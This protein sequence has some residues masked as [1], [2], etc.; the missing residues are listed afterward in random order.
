[1]TKRKKLV[2]VFS[3]PSTMTM[4][5]KKA[6]LND[7]EEVF[8][9]QVPSINYPLSFLKDPRLANEKKKPQQSTAPPLIYLRRILIGVLHIMHPHSVSMIQTKTAEPS[10]QYNYLEI[11]HALATAIGIFTSNF[12]LPP[13]PFPS[14]TFLSLFMIF[15]FIVFLYRHSRCF[16]STCIHANCP[17]V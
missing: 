1:M 16:R 11:Y 17:P 6:N 3:T 15:F 4:S 12:S 2:T 5:S 7:Q 14:L 8:L 10:P 13:P 9:K